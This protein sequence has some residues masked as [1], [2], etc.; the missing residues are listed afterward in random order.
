MPERVR[1]PTA[2]GPSYVVAT[3]RVLS[4]QAQSG[5]AY[6]VTPSDM[7]RRARRELREPWLQDRSEIDSQT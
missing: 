1:C 7:P 4:E 3:K 2:P 5:Y 6:L